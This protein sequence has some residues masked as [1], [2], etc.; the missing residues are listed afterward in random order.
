MAAIKRLLGARVGA[1]AAQN[2]A[3][4]E[5][6]DGS[7]RDE[8]QFSSA[9][10]HGADAASRTG[11]ARLWV[12]W[13]VCSLAI[14]IPFLAVEFPPITDLPQHSAQV[15]L[16]QEAWQDQNSVYR[17]QWFTPYSLQYAILAAGWLTVGPAAAGRFGML[18]IGVLWVGAAHLIAYRRQRPPAAAALVSLFFFTHTMYWGFYSF[19]L[20]WPVFA[21]WWLFTTGPRRN[22][23]RWANAPLALGA[24]LLLYVSHALWFAAAVLWLVLSTVALR[25]PLRAALVRALGLAPVVAAA[26]LWYPKLA[27]A[28]FTSVTVWGTT[29]SGRLSFSWLANAM[30]GGLRGPVELGIVALLGLWGVLVVARR[31]RGPPDGRADREL[32]L[33]AAMLLALAL[34]LPDQHSN[35][36]FFASRWMPVAAIVLVLGLPGL[37]WR[38]AA[39]GA[40]AVGAVATVSLG[41]AAAWAEFERVE[42]SGLSESL[43][44]LPAR[45]RVIG[46]DFVKGSAVVKGRPFLQAFAYAQVLRGG[47]LNFSFAQFAPS[48]VVFRSPRQTPWTRGLE[49]HSERFR[50]A[51]LRHFDHALVNAEEPVHRRFS[52]LP[53]VSPVTAG[54]PWRLYRIE[55]PAS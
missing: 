31:R 4:W 1:V 30:L 53:G 55:V 18:A 38:P 40:L 36:I 44:G 17:I 52:A 37:D 5:G 16:F 42:M 2:G 24:G 54:G 23:V 9:Q 32:L 50:P 49:W 19:A 33:A 43:A 12:Q 13:A 48:L 3:A 14:A 8:R 39:A 15:R 34:T 27:A 25:V 28:G 21:L 10:D 35:T 41:T 20:G 11:A 45:P 51:D 47:T 26:A 46:L 29:P 6:G 22:E 7:G